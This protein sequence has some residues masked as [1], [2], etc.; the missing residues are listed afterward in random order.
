[1]YLPV[2]SPRKTKLMIILAVI[3]LALAAAAF[4]VKT[5]FSI[6]PPNGSPVGPS[7]RAG[8]HIATLIQ[9]LEP[10]MVS[11]HRNPANDRYRVGLFLQPVDGRTPSRLIPIGKGFQAAQLGLI[12]L[13]D[14]DVVVVWFD[15][16]GL[17][18]VEVQSGK[19]VPA[20]DT[21]SF[22]ASA[23]NRD[24]GGA[25]QHFDSKPE[26][27]L[28]PSA[29]PTTT[30][31]LG[32]ISPRDA[33]RSY[34]QGSWVRRGTRAEDA[35]EVRQFYKGTL[36]PAPQWSAHELLSIT[37]VPAEGFLNTA[38]VCDGPDTE[39]IRL[40]GPDGF[41]MVYTSEPGLKGTLVV[42][43]ADTS[44]QLAWKVDTGLDR[45]LLRQIL[46][47]ARFI[48]FVGTR[49]PVQDKVSEPLLVVIDTQSGAVSTT[50][51]WQ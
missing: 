29:F 26:S 6:S 46:P 14:F 48:A 47:D 44:G 37:P 22:K 1:M 42:A 40:S 35:K 12:R 31:W 24:R 3:V 5:L 43:R 10:Y 18:G 30:E 41:L 27:H 15:V 49:L 2:N 7:L 28:A 16:T 25:R 21:Q 17:G 39:A 38:F 8:T 20:A 11:L 4:A 50:S 33:G 19:L 32:L 13:I 23:A 9:T 36:G 34:K 51:L 45:F